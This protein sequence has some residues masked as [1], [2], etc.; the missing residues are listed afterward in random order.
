MDISAA[1][2]LITN[3]GGTLATQFVALLPTIM[4]ILIPVALVIWGINLFIGM[5]RWGKREF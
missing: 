1:Q 5:F 4:D 3:I 2:D